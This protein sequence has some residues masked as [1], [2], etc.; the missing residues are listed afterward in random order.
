M[1]MPGAIEFLETAYSLLKPGGVLVLG[2]MRDT[3]P[4]L[5]FTTKVVRWPYIRPRSLDRVMD[6]VKKA[7]IN[8]KNVTL[9]Q[10]GDNVYTVAAITKDK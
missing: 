7:G 6:I 5:D 4:Q 10:A 9:Y 8:P 1:M 2:N 3:H